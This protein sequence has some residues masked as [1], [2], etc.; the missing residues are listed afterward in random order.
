MKRLVDAMSV[1]VLVTGGAGY[2]GAHVAKALAGAGYLPVTF[3]SL[4]RG[5]ARAVQWG[6]LEQGDLADRAALER[7]IRRWRPQAA[8]HFAAY[9]AVGESVTDPAR[10]WRNNVAAT[11]NLLEAMRDHDIQQLVFSSTAAVYGLPNQIPIR[12]SA[13][14]LPINPYG[15]TKL[16]VERMMSAFGAAYGL[17]AVALRYFNACGA[18]DGGAIGEA[19]EPET[20]LIPLAIQAALGVGPELQ[21]FGDDYPTF[22]GT[23]VRDYIHVE[24]LAIAHVQAL[25]YLRAGGASVACNV[26]TGSGLSVKQVIDAVTRHLGRP[27]PHRIAP[28]RA[29]DPP[30]LVADPSCAEQLL[31]WRAQRSDVD[32]IVASACAWEKLRRGLAS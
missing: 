17:R 6:P 24:D 16:A 3:D 15:E 14:L 2:V 29:G 18:D 8:L 28:R 30:E 31:A 32:R 7:A 13:P 22:D 25:G 23:C 11:L 27:V 20:H 19:H 21:L 5:F 12:E 26:G 9:I 10:Y 1:P 4:E